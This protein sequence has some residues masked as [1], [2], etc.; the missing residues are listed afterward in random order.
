MLHPAHLQPLRPTPQD[1]LRM[2][3]NSWI[4]EEK[5]VRMK[6]NV[7]LALFLVLGMVSIFEEGWPYTVAV[8][9]LIILLLVANNIFKLK[10]EMLQRPDDFKIKILIGCYKKRIKFLTGL[11]IFLI[12][13]LGIF[14]VEK[15]FAVSG[16][17][18]GR[19][20]SDA[21]PVWHDVAKVLFCISF[22]VSAVI[23]Y[24]RRIKEINEML[25][26]QTE[27]VK[28]A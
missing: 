12:P 16:L 5:E 18:F 6:G 25:S 19:E 15:Y 14:L 3:V 28:S 13:A 2:T 21:L 26:G 17:S 23:K 27:C 8:C 10:E 9:S 22:P 11:S 24:K 1:G 7:I 4:E 20:A